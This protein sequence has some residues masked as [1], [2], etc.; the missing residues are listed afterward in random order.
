MHQLF[1]YLAARPARKCIY[2]GSM[3]Q[4]ALQD[5]KTYREE[6]ALSGAQTKRAQKDAREVTSP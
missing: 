5:A 6:R 2:S 1:F 4:N 3:L